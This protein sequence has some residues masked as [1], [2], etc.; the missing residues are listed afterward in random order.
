[1]PKKRVTYF[2]DPDVGS[3]SYGPGHPMKPHRIRMADNLI[4]AYGMLDQMTVLRPPRATPS[5]MT[6]FHTDD[7]I[8]FLAKVTPETIE[9]LTNATGQR[10]LAGEDNP[11]F[12]GVFEFCSI[13]AGGSVA[14]AHY[15]NDGAT[16]IAIN[17][18]GG[19]H[20][21]KKRE[22]SGFCYINDINLAILELLRMFPRVLYIDIDCHHGDGV[23][24]AFYTTDRV[25]T[26]SF[27]K[28]GDYFPGTGHINDTGMGKG[29]GYSINVPLKDGL[30]DSAFESVFQPIID[31]ILDWYRPSAV[32]LQL[33]ADSLAGDKLG[34]FNITME[35][36]AMSVQYLRRTGLPLIL[37]GGG[38]YTTKNVARVWT[39]ET[40]CALGIENEINRDL[41]Y[42]DY[43]DWFGPR[44]RLEVVANNMEDCNEQDG[45]LDG[46]RYEILEQLRRLPFAPS[47]AL[48]QVPRQ[49]IV[50]L[51]AGKSPDAPGYQDEHD[52]LSE[53]DDRIQSELLV[54]TLAKLYLTSLDRTRQ[55]NPGRSH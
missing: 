32:V 55:A 20:H 29:L 19:L 51:L 47:V 25:L 22:A 41:P 16:D 44:Y 3:F 9:D 36:H 33:G 48:Q 6:T 30:T 52:E 4:A 38:G 24:E 46:V 43:F 13:S 7:Y 15:I 23:E 54:P 1:M 18:A 14:A 40:A 42:H 11:A 53:L 8:E 2:H 12:E 34:C 17:W 21:A 39:Y 27:H 5:E 37:L 10:F 31:H 28:F 26:C 45:Y 49:S 35:G 50:D